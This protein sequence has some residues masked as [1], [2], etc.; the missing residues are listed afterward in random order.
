MATG[1]FCGEILPDPEGDMRDPDYLDDETIRSAFDKLCASSLS[2][3][4]HAIDLFYKG[5]AEAMRAA[6]SK[7]WHQGW[8]D[9]PSDEF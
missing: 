6:Y 4:I 7:G 9:A 1:N 2:G 3:R 8:K 5:F